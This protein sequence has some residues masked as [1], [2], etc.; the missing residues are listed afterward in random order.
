MIGV[1]FAQCYSLQ[2]GTFRISEAISQY[3]FALLRGSESEPCARIGIVLQG[4]LA[5]LIR[6]VYHPNFARLIH[7][8]IQTRQC[9]RRFKKIIGM[10]TRRRFDAVLEATQSLRVRSRERVDWA[11]VPSCATDIAVEHDEEMERLS[12]NNR[13]RQKID[14]TVG[15]VLYKWATQ[16]PVV[17][18]CTPDHLLRGG[19]VYLFLLRRAKGSEAQCKCHTA[20]YASLQRVQA[21]TCAIQD[22]VQVR[23]RRGAAAQRWQACPNQR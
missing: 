16:Y 10:Q 18:V 4:A 2:V 6:G 14:L 7:L 5:A 15:N 19:R 21:S 12:L 22:S 1:E 20:T 17:D 23:G 13:K 11:A 3:F 8:S 9:D